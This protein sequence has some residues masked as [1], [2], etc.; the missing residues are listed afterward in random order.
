L[1]VAANAQTSAFAM[2]V[3]VIARDGHVLI[4]KR[5]HCDN[6]IIQ[7]FHIH[8]GA[9]S[10]GTHLYG[11]KMCELLAEHPDTEVVGLN[12]RKD[13]VE[14]T[15]SDII[16]SVKQ[17]RN[18]RCKVYLS[19]G[20]SGGWHVLGLVCNRYDDIGPL[21]GAMAFCPVADPDKRRRWLL[22]CEE[23][24]H[25]AIIVGNYSMDSALAVPSKEKAMLIRGA[26]DRF[27]CVTPPPPLM[28]PA[29][30][31]TL[32]VAGGLD[33]NVPRHLLMEVMPFVKL[34][35]YGHL[36]HNIQEAKN[37]TLVEREQL[38][39]DIAAFVN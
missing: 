18:L 38:K 1:Q 16:D 7:I 20:S 23:G 11:A 36:G 13:N 22:A 15:W 24:T 25:C 3:Q 28:F 34:V 26:Q 29:K 37:L 39:Q 32:V 27:F 6:P 21:D 5:W 30:C 35:M 2:E 33:E 8:G 31:R 9:F 14:S 10:T 4:H 17:L 12:F 19:G